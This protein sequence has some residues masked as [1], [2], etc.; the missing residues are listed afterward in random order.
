M[1]S[2]NLTLLYSF[3]IFFTLYSIQTCFSQTPDTLWTKIL[4]GSANEYGYYAEQTSDDGFILVGTTDA[5]GSGLDDVWL[6]KTNSS[7]DTLWTKTIGGSDYDYATCVHQTNDGGYIIFGETNSFDPNFWEGYMI[8]TNNSGTTLWTKHL[9]DYAY[10]FIEEGVEIPDSGYVFVGYTKIGAGDPEDLWLVKTDSAG[11]IIWTKTYGGVERDL[12]SSINRTSDGGFIIAGSTESF[13]TGDFDG[14]LIRTDSNGNLIWSKTYGNT[15]DNYANDVRQTDDGGFIIA[16]STEASNNYHDAWLIKTDYNGD[17]LWT[18]S[19]GSDG[20]DGAMSVVQTSD[21]GY[22]WTGYRKISTFNQDLWVVKTDLNGNAQWSKTYGGTFNNVGRSINK[23]SDGSLII[24]GEYYSEV[25]NTRDIWLLKFD[26]NISKVERDDYAPIPETIE[27]KQN[28]PNPFNPSTTIEFRIPESQ[29]IT[30]AVYN[31]LGEQV[32]L[33][34]NENLS[35]G[36]YKTDW[37]A[38]DLPSGIYIYNLL[39]GEF[40]LSKKMILLK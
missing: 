11:D 24:A 36:N 28:Y 37:D 8:K 38:S 34:V 17:T 5:F 19:W 6:I 1:L 32:G 29:F 35:A 9:G 25:T 33:L 27:L 18:R 3:L 26:P 22:V 2:K 20:H 10:Y 7:G 15:E 39:A 4:G 23:N 14:W 40:I 31:L 13:G 16:G 21:G 12:S 30:L